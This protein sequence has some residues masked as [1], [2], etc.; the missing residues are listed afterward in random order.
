MTLNRNRLLLGAAVTLLFALTTLCGLALSV[1]PSHATEITWVTKQIPWA[2]F[3]AVAAPAE[4]LQSG[5]R[6]RDE[7]DSLRTGVIDT[8]D[9]DWDAYQIPGSA[10]GIF[11]AATITITSSFSNGATDTIYY[12]VEKGLNGKFVRNN[13]LVATTGS[14]A[15]IPGASSDGTIFQGVLFADPDAPQGNNQVW[16]TPQF[17]ICVEGD[18]SGTTPI[19][20]GTKIFI[21]YPKR[22]QSR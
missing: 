10:G 7:N 18:Q 15:L 5:L 13:T 14:F 22:A 6:L 11:V 17:R 9:W 1:A 16:Q 20:Y 19:Q 2:R 12:Q 8:S 21:T 3:N 4:S